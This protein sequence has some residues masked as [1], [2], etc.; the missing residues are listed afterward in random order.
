MSLPKDF[1]PET[2]VTW[3]AFGVNEKGEFVSYVNILPDKAETAGMMMGTLIEHLVEC[4]AERFE[5]DVS[6]ELWSGVIRM[7]L[8]EDVRNQYIHLP[9]QGDES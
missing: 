8:A 1:E 3:L 6:N 4:Y 7:S 2:F 5:R 9:V